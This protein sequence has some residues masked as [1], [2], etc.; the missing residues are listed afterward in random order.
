MSA[1]IQILIL[2]AGK[3]HRMGTTKQM[4]PY[5]DRPLLIHVIDLA[6]SLSLGRP[7]VLLGYEAE[8]IKLSVTEDQAHL[9]VNPHWT[10]GMGNT[11]AWGIQKA[12]IE[13][14]PE[15]VLVLLADQP[16][17]SK[18]HLWRLVQEYRQKNAPIIATAYPNGGGV[19][20]IFDKSIFPQLLKLNGDHGAR[21]LIR[22][23]EDIVLISP[24]EKEVWDID[25]PEDYHRLLGDQ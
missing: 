13:S 4:L 19:P 6:N 25:T 21:R 10:K 1:E 9:I 3:G 11:L 22:N 20:A 14:K 8:K 12:A 2:A 15:A 24:P 7:I 17:I 5:L 23:Y 18:A 16:K